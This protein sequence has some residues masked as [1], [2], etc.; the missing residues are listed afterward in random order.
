[1]FG[2]NFVGMK[3]IVEEVPA[4]S[5]SAFRI[6]T[7]ALILVPLTPLLA[8][9][10]PVIPKRHQ[11]WP[12]ALAALLG[13]GLNQLLFALGLERTTPSHSSVIVATI[14]V[15]TLCAALAFGE[16][17]LSRDKLIAV[18]LAMLGVAILIDP[19]KSGEGDWVGDIYTF[20]NA[21]SYAVFLV[22]VRRAGQ[23]LASAATTAACFVFGATMLCVAAIPSF[24][25]SH[26][27]PLFSPELGPWV[28]HSIF[29]AT[30]GA[31]LLNVWALQHTQSSMVALYIYGQ[32]ILATSLSIAFG[33]EGL[34]PDLFLAAGFVFTAVALRVVT[35][36][37]GNKRREAQGLGKPSGTTDSSPTKTSAE[38]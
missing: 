2:A 14:P 31:Y 22:Y 36:A 21:T 24:Q 34:E 16:E 30:I 33:I 23:G 8:K 17:R 25:W 6:L 10:Q 7:A 32:P 13:I 1:M 11:L 19:Q 20:L 27:E 37:R 28:L 35:T 15:L 26:L 4:L 5:W 9:G 38:G 12:L 29:G 3:L 18:A